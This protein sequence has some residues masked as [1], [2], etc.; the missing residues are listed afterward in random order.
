M[1]IQQLKTYNV[2]NLINTLQNELEIE[3][4]QIES[5]QQ[6][7]NNLTAALLSAQSTLEQ[8]KVFGL[9]LDGKIINDKIPACAEFCTSWDFW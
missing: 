5:M 2:C 1:T 4:N 8:K 9:G 6:N 3:N 7:I